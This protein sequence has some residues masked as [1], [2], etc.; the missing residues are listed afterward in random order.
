MLKQLELMILWK[1]HWQ[2]L[3]INMGVFLHLQQWKCI[4]LDST[5]S[6][7]VTKSDV[8]MDPWNFLKHNSTLSFSSSYFLNFIENN[9]KT[10]Q[11]TV[12]HG[13]A[14]KLLSFI[15][16]YSTLFSCF[17]SLYVS[18]FIKFFSFLFFSLV[19]CYS[20]QSTPTT[21]SSFFH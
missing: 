14:I 16:C 11:I 1:T 18:F 12:V 15:F 13:S 19:I 6:Y 7:L 5:S 21:F 10:H 20:R 4:Y 17:S 3:N 8:R 9:K 2:H